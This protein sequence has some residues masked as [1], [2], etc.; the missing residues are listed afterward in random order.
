M[1]LHMKQEKIL[2]KILEDNTA[3][4][5]KPRL[6][7]FH[8][9]LN[10]GPQSIA[11]LAGRS[12]EQVDRV[13]VYRIIDFYEKLGIVKRINIGWKYKV[14]L[15]DIFLDHHHHITCLGCNKL[16]AVQEDADM[17]LRIAN[18]AD[19]AGFVII[20]HQLELQGYCEQCRAQQGI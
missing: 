15:S 20:S 3:K 16:V 2:R 1:L 14:E 18:L 17:A 8:L 6:I 5:T 19:S 10:H 4:V 13:S 9:L 7:I 11:E 12:R